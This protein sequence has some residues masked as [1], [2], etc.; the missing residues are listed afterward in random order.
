MQCKSIR[1]ESKGESAGNSATV[2]KEDPLTPLGLTGRSDAA[3]ACRHF[4]AGRNFS[5]GP[6]RVGGGKGNETNASTETTAYRSP[7]GRRAFV[8]LCI[9]G[10]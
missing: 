6:H 9:A 10:L 8:H 2:R 7:A 1:G 5:A 4:G 3:G